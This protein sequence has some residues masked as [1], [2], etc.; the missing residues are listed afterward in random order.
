MNKERCTFWFR[1]LGLL[2]ALMVAGIAMAQPPVSGAVFTTDSTCTGVDLNIYQSKDDV[3]L[4]GGPH[5][6]SSAGLPDGY[7]Y[8]QVTEPNG[9][10]LGTSVGTANPTPVHV[11]NG[12]FDQCYQLSSILHR[13]SDGGPTFPIN[14]YDDT[15]N[16][17]GVYKVWVSNV[18][19]FDN[20][21]S[22]TDNF[23]APTT[24]CLHPPCQPQG[25]QDLTVSK[26][27]TPS[28]KRAYTWKSAK[29][30]DKTRV[31]QVGGSATFNYTIDVTKDSGTDS[32]WKVT[33]TI[34]V[35]NPNAELCSFTGVDVTDFVGG[36]AAC[37]V[38]SGT[39]QTIQPNGHIDLSYTCI[40]TSQPT[41]ASD[42]NTAEAN[43]PDNSPTIVAGFAD[44]TAAF[45]FGAV[46][47]TLVGDSVTVTD[48]YA[49]T[50]GT[51]SSSTRFTY[52]RTIPV[53]QFGCQSYDNTAT[54]KTNDTGTTGSASRTVTVCGP[55]RTGALTMGFWQ[56]KN[57]QSIISGGASVSGVCKSGTWLRQ[58]APFQDLGATATC[59][60]VAT[61]VYNVIKAANA[62]GTSMNAM[63]KAQMLA[64]SLDVY[65]SDPALGGNKIT[66]P[67]PIG[68]VSFDLTQVCKMIDGTGGTATC[69][70]TYQNTSAAFG[71]A[72]CLTVSQ[73]L[74]Y[75]ATLSNAGGSAWYG[76]LK[77]TQELAKNAFDAINNQVAFACP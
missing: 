13:A 74:A 49:G 24:A 4:N 17:G 7:Y 58:Y 41:P 23:K 59:S 19:T 63:L 72:T 68:G 43:W 47:P 3:Y 77:A 35:T 51:A 20:D 55:A 65:F 27:A 32:D 8:V 14:G 53:P 52:A 61:Y 31:E 67:A 54:F 5:H 26:T 73:M 10:V 16:P 62:S 39:G 56:N 1:G 22:K 9:F 66:A 70:G 21:S 38:T 45:D 15:S 12:V 29:S 18:S 64:T 33:G 60:Q 42:T 75:A 34:T 25:C 40:Y 2:A 46:S 37:T 11:T 44:G 71:G 6:G 50:L 69:S 57:G 28:F 30:V 36:N 48:S 76:Q